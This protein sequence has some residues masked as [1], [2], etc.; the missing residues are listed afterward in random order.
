MLMDSFETTITF[1]PAS[2]AACAAEL[3]LP[4]EPTTIISHSSFLFFYIIHKRI[5]NELIIYFK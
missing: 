4:P 3:P 5:I 2:A 1:S